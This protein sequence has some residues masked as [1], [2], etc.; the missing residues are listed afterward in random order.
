[1]LVLRLLALLHALLLAPSTGGRSAPAGK[2]RGMGHG[3][4]SSSLAADPTTTSP[5]PGGRSALLWIDFCDPA[6]T[7]GCPQGCCRAAAWEDVA[8]GLARFP[9]TSADTVSF[10]NY[11]ILPDG[12]FGSEN[13][14][15]GNVSAVEAL[16]MPAVRRRLPLVQFSADIGCTA[17][18]AAMRK[19]FADSQPFITAA[20]AKA[21]AL[22]LSM[23]NLDVEI[24][25]SLISG[26][27]S[28][29]MM[30][31]VSEFA[32]ALHASGR[33][34]SIDLGRC[35]LAGF[36]GSFRNNCS[37]WVETGVDKVVTM[38]TYWHQM[39]QRE[40]NYT[41]ADWK[42]EVTDNAEV[43]G[44]ERYIVGIDSGFGALNQSKA[45]GARKSTARS[46]KIMAEA[47]AHLDTQQLRTVAVWG[48]HAVDDLFVKTLGDWLSAPIFAAVA[49]KSDDAA[50]SKASGGIGLSFLASSS[51]APLKSDDSDSGSWS[52]PELRQV[53]NTEGF[54]T[55]SLDGGDPFPP[56]WLIT[57]RVVE[58]V[59]T[60]AERNLNQ[61]GGPNCSSSA[62]PDPNCCSGPP[63]CL[64]PAYCSQPAYGCS[65]PDNILVQQ[66]VRAREA[67]IP[68]VV[69]GSPDT[70][71]GH[72]H[73]S[74]G[75]KQIMNLISVYH[76][77][78]AVMFRWSVVNVVD[79]RFKSD[80]TGW[81]MTL[82]NIAN[83]NDI[84]T[85]SMDSPTKAWAESVSANF[86]AGLRQL[87]KA[88]PGKI[89]GIQF[90]GL[91]TGEWNLPTSASWASDYSRGMA[92]D[93]CSS[94]L[95]G[96][97]DVC[98]LPTGAERARATLGNALLQWN[99]S[100]EPSA[101]SF[102]YNM[103]ISRQVTQAI[104]MLA[105]AVK[106]VSNG[107]SLA[108]A[109]YGYDFALSDY[110]LTGSGHLDLPSLM[111]CKDLDGVSSPYQYIQNARQ[112]EGRLTVHGPQDS[113]PL[114]GKM[115]VVEDDS[116]TALS[117]PGNFD[118]YVTDAAGTVNLL[119]RNLYTSML[120]KSA[121]YFFDLLGRGWFG[122]N[123]TA[124]DLA[125]TDA[126]WNSTSHALSQW[127]SMLN[128]ST[129]TPSIQPEVAIF[130]DQ[131]SS[132]ARPLLGVRKSFETALL[133]SPWQ[134]IAGVG[135][136]VRVHPLSDLLL[137]NFTAKGIKMA[138]MLNAA[139]I[140]AKLREA[141][142]TK[143]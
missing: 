65:E 50:S 109:Y 14:S 83:P 37:C 134:D 130:V 87:D 124:S 77:S 3:G 67:G 35:R 30:V 127:K 114:S 93:F 142:K 95:G 105:A 75:V 90:E 72:M 23:Y 17:G 32:A 101:V 89:A 69:V 38:Q 71:S 113:L 45:P 18:I 99:R 129:T 85:G 82:Q 51:V 6:Y 8:A 63:W 100:T 74:V 62:A 141:I 123:D 121:I 56:F 43:L 42:R 103:F 12:S 24:N 70:E 81:K 84:T 102:R 106:Q 13:V 125:I 122:R 136:P 58:M 92:A 110:M 16:G 47:L 41:L 115:W 25:P 15:P 73:I 59:E 40:P 28:A 19:L 55:L 9:L 80:S 96:D 39:T 79:P 46:V 97:S 5:R 91:W 104:S 76:P 33:R 112:P 48:T 29:D 137:S 86:T 49:A 44:R 53:S 94:E 68:L 1:M 120:K 31:F 118:R 27:D 54:P 128:H 34:L 22:N 138:V 132:A 4:K 26:K 140:S 2:M 119:R 10:V 135:A 36:G 20:V 78:A 131:L 21:S 61:H 66:L 64:G 52:G 111:R 143:L 126:I 11:A 139:M 133:Q 7:S 107:K 116:R 108:M 60:A 98:R 57:Q 88:F 117:A